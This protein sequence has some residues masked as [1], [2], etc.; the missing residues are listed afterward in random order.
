MAPNCFRRYT[1]L[2]CNTSAW[3]KNMSIEIVRCRIGATGVQHLSKAAWPKLKKIDFNNQDHE[4]PNRNIIG[5]DGIESIR[6]FIS[7]CLFQI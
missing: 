3:V 2:R 5:L 7:R 6:K 4:C 1:Y